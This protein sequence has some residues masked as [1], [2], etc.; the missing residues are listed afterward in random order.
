MKRQQS[1]RRYAASGFAFVPKTAA[2]APRFP[3]A[4]FGRVIELGLV[5]MFT[6]VPC[7][8]SAAAGTPSPTST[9]A[10]LRVHGCSF[11]A[12]L[13]ERTP[14]RRRTHRIQSQ[15]AHAHVCRDYREPEKIFGLKLC[16]SAWRRT[17]AFDPRQCLQ[18]NFQNNGVNSTGRDRSWLGRR[19]DQKYT[20]ETERQRAVR[21]ARRQSRPE[22]KRRSELC[23]R[24]KLFW[25]PSPATISR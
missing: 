6:F 11:R 21:H 18:I 3:H 25:Q 10:R 12:T 17:D 19:S 7:Y 2:V 9:I 24:N 13:A 14:P 15:S 20:R 4:A 8:P 23:D 5:P 1:R 16:G 22:E